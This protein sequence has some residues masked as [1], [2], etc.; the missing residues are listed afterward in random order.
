M[1]RKVFERFAD[2]EDGGGAVIGG[3]A[4]HRSDFFPSDVER[5]DRLVVTGIPETVDAFRAASAGR[6]LVVEVGPGRGLFASALAAGRPGAVVLAAETRLGSCLRTLSR[7]ERAGASNLWVAWGDGRATLPLL[8]PPGTASE[9]YLLFPDPWWKR[10]HARRRHGPAMAAVLATA[11]A[12]GGL[13]VV[14]SDV[15]AYLE[16]IVETFNESGMFSPAD[17]PADLPMT[18][19]EVRLTQTGTKTVAA[20]LRRS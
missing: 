6:P 18:D 16:S 19:R 8:V 4:R 12:P 17:A 14:K 1:A 7:A 9:A 10:S 11:L 3:L 2:A 20:A 15:P 13:L 5:P